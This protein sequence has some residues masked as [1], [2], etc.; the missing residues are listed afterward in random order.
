[1]QLPP[2]LEWRIWPGQRSIY[3]SMM[4]IMNIK[5]DR[6][7]WKYLFGSLFQHD[8]NSF[9]TYT[10][11][12]CKQL[13]AF[14]FW[15]FQSIVYTGPQ[16]F[17]SYSLDSR[18]ETITTFQNWFNHFKVYHIFPEINPQ[19]ELLSLT[20]SHTIYTNPL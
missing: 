10:S 6:A 19:N 4:A 11:D 3:N 13:P 20:N 9:G 8:A 7:S 1:M 18:N 17:R 2:S 16:S 15:Q 5:G 12:E 14:R